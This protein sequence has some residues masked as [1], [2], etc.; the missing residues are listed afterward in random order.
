MK[1][2]PWTSYR[3]SFNPQVRRMLFFALE[4]ALLQ[5]V[6]SVVGFGNVLYAT[7]M[8][9]TDTQI[10]LIQTIP[11]L[12][13]IALML[14]CGALSDRMRTA[15]AL[16]VA[17]SLFMGVTYL[18]YGTVPVMGASRLWFFF[19]FLACTNGALA[20]YN[21]QWQSF[22][23]EAVEP[24][25]RNGIYAFRNRFLFVV[26]TLAPLVCGIALSRGESSEEKLLV[27]RVFYYSCALAMFGIAFALS[28]IA[29]PR[30]EKKS[31]V[32][33][34]F[35]PRALAGAVRVMAAHK[36][37]RVFFGGIL[38]FYLTWHIDWSL[39]YIGEIQY[40]G[41]SEW[42][43][44][45]VNATASVASLLS[46]GLWARLNE[47]G[48]VERTFP[49]GVA[50]L[51]GSSISMVAALCLPAALR[52]GAFIVMQTVSCYFQGCI[53]L[54]VV[55]MLLKSVPEENKALCIS[56]YTIAITL[57]NSLMPLLGV[58]VYQL[59]GANL[60][61]I[62][63]FYGVLLVLRAGVVGYFV[64]RTRKEEAA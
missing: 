4:G 27:L 24:P 6:S 16:P 63:I 59:M 58:T 13:A 53:T 31:A 42:Q 41:L 7:N 5:Y 29:C 2:L 26:G 44:S 3:I 20:T 38:L 57:S 49:F 52:P 60:A 43:L 18:A 50:G 37:F 1:R 15:R 9:A 35:S 39:W 46:V 11:N 55:Q 34:M 12:A 22:F 45:L 62:R 30:R 64:L 47:K 56:L 8:G 25:Q 17:I 36:P 48:S 54:C 10:G 33:P 21:A 40:V 19:V 51:M 14:P 23:G 32:P 28:R 61:A